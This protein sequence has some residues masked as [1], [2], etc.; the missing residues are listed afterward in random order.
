MKCR[1]PERAMALAV[2]VTL[3]TAASALAIED[4][5]VAGAFSAARPGAAMPAGWVSLEAAN[6]KVRTRYTLVDDNGVTVLR[7]DS[8]SGASGLSRS[9]RIDPAEMPWLRWRWKIS[10]IIDQ[11]DLRTRQGDDFP[12]RVYVMFDYPL[13][14]LPFLERNKLR[15]A[16]ALFDPNL[17]AATL[18]YV[19][20]GKAPAGTMVPSA[21]TGRVKV[22]VVES[23]AARARQW[24]DVERNIARDFRAAFGEEAPSVSAVAVATD[25]DNTGT[26]AT[27]FFGDISFNKHRVTVLPATADGKP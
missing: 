21:Y 9:V 14:K 23:G 25:T 6:I 8:Q 1:R 16:R 20:D 17:P 15:L 11:A 3:L 22:I 4:S 5:M 26:T 27:A 10:N 19:W 18:C 2:L 24:V 7:A 13:E 12:A